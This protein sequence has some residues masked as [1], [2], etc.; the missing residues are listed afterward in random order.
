MNHPETNKQAENR[1]QS[2]FYESARKST[3]RACAAISTT[4]AL[5]SSFH[6]G[7]L[8]GSPGWNGTIVRPSCSTSGRAQVLHF[9]RRLLAAGCHLPGRPAHRFRHALFLVTA[10]AGRLFCGYACPQTV[11]TQLFMWIENWIEGDRNAR[12]KLDKAP[13]DARKLRIKGTKHLLW[14]ALSLWTGFTLVGY[15]TRSAN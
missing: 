1:L 4:G 12:I 7:H 13:M 6:P 11:Y 14:L 10:V 5:A 3:P 9:R 15:F 8:Y 2:F